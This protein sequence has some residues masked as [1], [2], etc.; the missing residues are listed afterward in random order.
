[1]SCRRFIF[2]CSKFRRDSIGLP[3]LCHYTICEGSRIGSRRTRA[4]SLIPS[5]NHWR[6]RG[7]GDYLDLQAS[8]IRAKMLVATTTMQHTITTQVPVLLLISEQAPKSTEL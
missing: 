6:C 7:L 3:A 8:C 1:M 2:P 5:A 4:N